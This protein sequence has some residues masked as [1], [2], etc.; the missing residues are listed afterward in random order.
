MNWWAFSL[1]VGFFIAVMII[2]SNEELD[3]VVY[4]L[5]FAV[6]SCIV[7]S[8]FYGTSYN[9]FV[10]FVDFKPL[11]FIFSM[12]LLIS[13]AEKHKIFQWIAVK[14]LHITKG[15]HRV[16]FYTICIVSTL[17][18]SIIAD[19]TVA[20]IFIPLVIRAC[21]IL[22]IKPR[23]YLFGITIT[24]NIGSILTPFSSSENILISDAFNLNIPW[25]AKNLAFFSFITLGITLLALEYTVFKGVKA[26]T[27]RKKKV[28]LE[29][30]SPDLV[31]SDKKTFQLNAGYLFIVI[32]GLIFIKESY[33]VAFI[34]ALVLGLIDDV[35]LSDSIKKIDW[36]LIFFILSLFL[37][38]GSMKVIGIFTEISDKLERLKEAGLMATAVV[39]L[40]ISSFMSGIL[41]NAPTTIAF[42]NIISRLYGPNPPV[43]IV[44]ALLLGV[45]LGG[46]I[47]PQG[48]ACDVM[49]LNIATKN[50][51]EG[52]N[53]KTLLKTGGSFALFHLVLCIIFIIIMVAI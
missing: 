17:L 23:P 9:E 44:A 26:P 40:V 4:A 52:F 25:F 29:I 14:T 28:L 7:T 13:I 48:A 47:L 15:N 20:I 6:L 30:M 27:D 3:Y 2:F 43:A 18:A 53:Y 49:T 32:M 39:F 16:F 22:E 51:V 10:E 11:I 35:R 33:I 34:G 50:N 12:Q 21:R 5:I 41:A 19:V 46:N 24:I 8:F 38:I 42:I 1:V 31:I 37:M 36:N 45:N